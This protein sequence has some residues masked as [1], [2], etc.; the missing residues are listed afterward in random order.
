MIGKLKDN[1]LSVLCIR[2]FS[3]IIVC[4][5]LVC[6]KGRSTTQ[7]FGCSFFVVFLN[8]TRF[9]VGFSV[10]VLLSS[11]AFFLVLLGLVGNEYLTRFFIGFSVAALLSSFSFS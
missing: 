10:A 3:K 2:F 1:E 9:F 5:S 7:T 11:F 6:R 4:C 8:L